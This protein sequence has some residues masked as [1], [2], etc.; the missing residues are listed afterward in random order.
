MH[1]RTQIAESAWQCAPCRSG[2]GNSTSPVWVLFSS[3]VSVA[4]ACSLDERLYDEVLRPLRVAS[5]A[6]VGEHTVEVIQF[7]CMKNEARAVVSC[8]NR[9]SESH[10]YSVHHPSS[11]RSSVQAVIR[12]FWRGTRKSKRSTTQGTTM[13]GALLQVAERLTIWSFP[14]RGS[15]FASPPLCLLAAICPTPVVAGGNPQTDK[16]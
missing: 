8:T 15:H 12:R 13:K 10:T 2:L 4:A 16:G 5:V 9:L 7:P 6:N 14:T 1:C 11:R 3:M